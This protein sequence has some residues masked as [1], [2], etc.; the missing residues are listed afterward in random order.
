MEAVRVILLIL[1]VHTYRL[2]YENKARRRFAVGLCI[3]QSTD[4]S[5]RLSFALTEP[6]FCG[7]LCYARK[8]R[9]WRCAACTISASN[10]ARTSR[11]SGCIGTSGFCCRRQSSM[12]FTMKAQE[13]KPKAQTEW[14]LSCKGDAQCPQS[15]CLCV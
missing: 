2:R 3:L 6:T 5:M 10:S 1:H 7:K 11:P 12:Y 14:Q 15:G 13:V 4:C 9:T 8:M